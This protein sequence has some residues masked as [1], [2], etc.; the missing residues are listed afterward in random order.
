MSQSTANK[1]SIF[2]CGLKLPLWPIRPCGREIS[3]G[4]FCGDST[5]ITSFYKELVAASAAKVPPLVTWKNN[6]FR[7]RIEYLCK[8]PVISAF[9]SFSLD[10]CYYSVTRRAGWKLGLVIKCKG[11]RH[12]YKLQK[13][14]PGDIRVLCCLRKREY[15]EYLL[16][17]MLRFSSEKV[18]LVL[19]N[20]PSKLSKQSKRENGRVS[21]A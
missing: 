9:E 3:R 7:R 17:A 21:L 4:G 15:L 2:K 16:T 12:G 8:P 5:F 10:M 14:N 20:V 1:N 13:G 18:L 11:E 19:L 6:L